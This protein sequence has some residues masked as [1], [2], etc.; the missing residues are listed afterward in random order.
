METFRGRCNISVGQAC[1]KFFP[2]SEKMQYGVNATWLA[3]R[4][5]IGS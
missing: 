3:I 1:L 5:K 2:A 4:G